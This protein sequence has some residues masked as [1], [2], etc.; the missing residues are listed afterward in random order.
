MSDTD[1]GQVD[2]AVEPA[3]QD[4]QIS[5]DDIRAQ[6]KQELQQE[7]S[8]EKEKILS[9]RDQILQEK[10]DLEQSIKGLDPEKFEEYKRFE[11]QRKKDELTD[12]LM[13]GKTEQAMNM[14]MEGQRKAWNETQEQYEERLKATSTRAEELEQKLQAV[15]QEKMGLKKNQY[16][17]DLVSQDESFKNE[18]FS[19]FAAL[20]GNKADIDEATGTVYALDDKG[21]R[22]VSA[23]GSFVKFED[24]YAKQKINHGLFWK[25]GSGS[26]YKGGNGGDGVPSGDPTKWNQEDK[27][28]F[29]RDN[30]REAYAELLKKQSK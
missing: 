19:D 30:G 18:Y 26:G 5:P 10:R 27:I 17:K 29:I 22:M 9:N 12:L 15:E 20:Y 3:K 1:T 14:L 13:Q 21:K 8:Q 7:W 16:L 25:G 23:D 24:F 11:E 6:L 2:Q 28:N 4:K